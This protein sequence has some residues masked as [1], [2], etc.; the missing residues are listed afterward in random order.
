MSLTGLLNIARSG[1]MAQSGALGITGQNVTN[2][3][4]A[5]YTKRVA[6]MSAQVGG[7]VVFNGE[8]RQF[9][10]F[11]Y[12]HVVEQSGRFA[13][14]DARSSA[15]SRI[16]A[17]VA[18]PSQTI[19]D[20]STALV[21]SFTTL[22]G[23]PLDAAVRAD[24]LSKADD[25]ASSIASTALS[26]SQTSKEILQEAQGV[27]GEINER[28]TR[29]AGLNTQIAAAKAEGA[30]ASTLRDQRDQ[31]IHE[32]GDRVGVKAVEDPQGRVT[33]FGA[34][35]VLVEGNKARPMTLDLDSSGRMRMSVNGASAIDV[36]ARIDSG[37]LGGLREAR[38]V[39]LA[40]AQSNLD[41]YAFDVGNTM[42]AAHTAGFG[43]DGGSGRALFSVSAT[44]VG[45]ASS[46]ALDAG[47]RGQPDK[48][49]SAG[50][51]A[52]LP[53]GN[54]GAMALAQLSESDS[55]GGANL[56]N[57]FASLAGDVGARKSSAES[58]RALRQ[59]TLSL[60]E[61]MSDSASG[62]S[63][64]EEMVDM[65]KYQRA[66]EAASKVLR[67]ADELLANFLRDI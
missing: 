50:S 67:T 29:V 36:T 61:T 15:L 23:Y 37:A 3:T 20:R 16:E 45:A 39:D 62:V 65:S 18:P 55:F 47:M 4:T 2:A 43:V 34:G 13:A 42:N 52:E 38:D 10:R 53:G 32:I 49:A 46:F 12:A 6:S 7:G 33:L 57:R 21:A 22:A 30:D 31:W 26:L 25:F 28:L 9:D 63:L 8:V 40:K 24:V 11:A 56:A 41:A 44:Q 51:T 14:A 48:I 54:S 59:D 17:I 60:A 58:E 5:G 27:V 1:M 66:F 64:D 19:G 35:S